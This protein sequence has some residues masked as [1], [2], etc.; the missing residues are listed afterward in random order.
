MRFSFIGR[1]PDS[2]SLLNRAYL[3]Q[4]YFPDFKIIQAHPAEDDFS[5]NTVCQDVKIIQSC[6]KNFSKNQTIYCG[7]SATAFRFMALRAS[8][9]PG[10]FVL[11]GSKRLFQRPHHTLISI[12]SQLGVNADYKEQESQLIV[13]G[14]GW[15]LQGDALVFSSEVSSQFASSVLLNSFNLKQD[16]FVSIEGKPASFAYLKMTQDFL[17]T[18]NFR[19]QG[20]FPEF[21]IP[22]A[23]KIT[24]YEYKPEPDMSCLFSL[25]AFAFLNGSAVFTDWPES[26][27]QPDFLF[28]SILS[29]MGAVVSNTEGSLK[30]KSSEKRK[31]ISVNLKSNPDLFPSLAVLC[32]LSE[33]ESFLYGALNLAFKESNRLMLT[34]ELI[35]KMGR[36]VKIED[37]GLRITGFSEKGKG[38]KIIFNPDRDHRMVMASALLIYEDFDVKIKDPLCVDKSFP[39]FWKAIALDSKDYSFS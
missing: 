16:L 28:P 33:G 25:S 36:K 9:K 32:A 14:E 3:V 29:E 7:D 37:E 10:R 4:S 34:A 27:F 11:S 39:Q 24:Q 8:R 31:G 21:H 23:Q 5:K 1:G 26:S 20:K 30:I 18:L 15:N 35:Q 6:L 13:E 2:K 38:R 22:A 17:K 19:V 12:L